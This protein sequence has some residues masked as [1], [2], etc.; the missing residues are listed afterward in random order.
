MVCLF[1]WKCPSMHNSFDFDE[2]QFIFLLLPVLS[3][4]ITAKS[5]A[6]KISSIFS[7]K[8]SIVLTLI[9]RGGPF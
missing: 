2:V 8:S 1:N 3:C 9:F 7:S 5:K 4:R 6:M